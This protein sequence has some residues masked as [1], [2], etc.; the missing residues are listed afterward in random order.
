MSL[1]LF[2]CFLRSKS[3]S[4]LHSITPG[5]FLGEARK[6]FPK[7][8]RCVKGKKIDGKSVRKIF[9]GTISPWEER[10]GELA[11]D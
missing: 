9:D 7:S 6:K 2:K 11:R 8:K 4:Y 5:F 10:E 1:L 3:F